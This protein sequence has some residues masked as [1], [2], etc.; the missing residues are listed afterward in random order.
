MIPLPADYYYEPLH[1]WRMC[2]QCKSRAGKWIWLLARHAPMR[3]LCDKCVPTDEGIRTR[4]TTQ[5]N[6]FI[7]VYERG[8]PKELREEDSA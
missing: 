8:R 4:Y 7:D 5:Q 1:D 6:R 2:E 3:V